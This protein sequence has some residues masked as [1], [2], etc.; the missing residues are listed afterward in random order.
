MNQLIESINLNN[1]NIEELCPHSFNNCD[2]LTKIFIASNGLRIIHDDTF[3]NIHNLQSLILNHNNIVR[4]P[5]SFGPSTTK[6]SSIYLVGA[7]KDLLPFI[8]PYF[9]C[10]YWFARDKHYF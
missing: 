6:L 3:D 4:L 1:K 10:I 7:L 8:Y 5:A 9:F 2:E